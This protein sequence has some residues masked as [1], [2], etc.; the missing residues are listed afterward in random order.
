[1][2]GLLRF[3]FT[4][5]ALLLTLS[6]QAGET[7]GVT[8][9]EVVFGAHTPLSGPVAIWGVGSVNA[10]RM[11]FDEVNAAGGVHGRQLRFIVEDTQYQVPRAIQA[12]NKLL[13]RDRIFAMLAALG[14][15][16]NNAVLPQQLA[17]NVPNVFPYTGAKAMG[18]PFHRLKFTLFPSYYG[19]TRAGLKYFVEHKGKRAICI[20]Y[21]DTDF[22]QE[23]YEGVVDQLQALDMRLV[24]QGK[25]Q[26]ADTDFATAVV[27]L[28]KAG[29]DLVVLGTIIKDTVTFIAAARKLGWEVD[30]LGTYSA[31]EPF[32]AEYEGGYTE[33]FYALAPYEVQYFDT[34]EPA[35]KAWMERYQAEFGK[36]PDSSA[37]LGRL[38][39]D[40]T[41]LA[42]E[43]AGRELTVDSFIAGLES[44]RDYPAF[45]ATL[46]F[47]PDKHDGVRE[48][49]LGVVDNKRW[50]MI[51]GP[52]H[53]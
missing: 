8:D 5:F 1:M 18:D 48:A 25:H 20:Q 11:R 30:F 23:V 32:V 29:C 7:Q 3:S 39:A 13:N 24:E 28:R 26:P 16:T 53:Y 2:P 43:R 47:G 36:L 46:D 15:S 37:A 19:Q 27:K 42:L 35:V 22:G 38:A 44:I 49:R 33:G 14:A 41:V 40:L 50:K 10:I 21:Q 51:T 12:A 34:A 31:Y 45:G 17:M 6:A 4:L 9:T 52:L